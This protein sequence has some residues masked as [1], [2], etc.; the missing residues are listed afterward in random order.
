MPQQL[1]ISRVKPG[2][3]FTYNGKR[4]MRQRGTSRGQVFATC[5]EP[6]SGLIS[7]GIYLPKATLVD[8]AD[9]STGLTARQMRET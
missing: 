1:T 7:D 4:Y 6:G 8:E 5:M 2:G 9:N 3:T